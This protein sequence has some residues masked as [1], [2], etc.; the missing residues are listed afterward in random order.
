[1]EDISRTFT[2]LLPK[3]TKRYISKSL[4]ASYLRNF[5]FLFFV[6]FVGIILQLLVF[7]NREYILA[8]QIYEKRSSDFHYWT[9]IAEQYPNMPDILFNASVS[10]YNVGQKTIALNYLDKALQLD[11]LFEK[12][13]IFKGEIFGVQK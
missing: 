9:S 11:P 1:M 4:M 12:A 13:R 8:K 7:L 5:F 3:G 10:A 6:I 2:A